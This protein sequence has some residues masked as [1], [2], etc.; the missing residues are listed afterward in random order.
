[1][2]EE[3]MSIFNKKRDKAKQFSEV[4][5]GKSKKEKRKAEAQLLKPEPLPVYNGPTPKY[6]NELESR[7]CLI[8]FRNKAQQDLIGNLFSVR[9]SVSGTIYITNIALLEDIATK[10]QSGEYQLVDEQVIVPET[11]EPTPVR[12]RRG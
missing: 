4:T 9:E 12:R 5:K 10:V 2:M 6:K 7:T 1:M 11:R 3:T 8:V